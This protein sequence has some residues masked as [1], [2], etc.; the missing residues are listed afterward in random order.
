MMAMET[1]DLGEVTSAAQ[2]S[3]DNAP[4]SLNEIQIETPEERLISL[5]NIYT[6]SL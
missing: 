3:E 5:A 6:L 2:K 1:V 4:V